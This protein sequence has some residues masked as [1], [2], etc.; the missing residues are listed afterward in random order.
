[1]QHNNKQQTKHRTLDMFRLYMA[2]V[3]GNR[4]SLK[5]YLHKHVLGKPWPGQLRITD[6]TAREV[7]HECYD[8]REPWQQVMKRT[9][10]FDFSNPSP[11]MRYG[12]A[13]GRDRDSNQLT[14]PDPGNST[15]HTVS[16]YQLLYLLCHCP[17]SKMCWL[18]YI[19]QF[20]SIY[21]EAREKSLSFFMSYVWASSNHF[22]A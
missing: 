3:A 9:P 6:I 11:F 14:N 8:K 12:P 7:Q 5:D 21:C 18:T 16:K 2:N 4:C 20:F 10:S 13:V 19:N 22:F 17:G 1:M 15:V